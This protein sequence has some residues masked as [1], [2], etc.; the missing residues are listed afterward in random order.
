[1][2]WSVESSGYVDTGVDAYGRPATFT[3]RATTLPA[4]S[5]ATASISGTPDAPVLNLGIPKGQD[6][7]VLSVN[8][9][10]GAVQLNDEHIPST[11]N[12]K[13]NVEQVLSYH[14][15]QIGDL[16]MQVGPYMFQIDSSGHLILFYPDGATPPPF[17]LASN[18][19]LYYDYN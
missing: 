13:A 1:M 12:G 3:A 6:S 7:A 2:Q 16:E 8:G 18:G 17:R 10:T 5:A 9:Q 15:Q 11:V 4:G 14:S 19:H